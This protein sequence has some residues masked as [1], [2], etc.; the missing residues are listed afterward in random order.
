MIN[1]SYLAIAATSLSLALLLAV[2][3]LAQEEA[4]SEAAA[5]VSVE[6]V[7]DTTVTETDLDAATP[8]PF[9]FLKRAVRSVQQVVTFDP[10]KKA[11]LNLKTAHEELL[12]AQKII[13]DNPGDA[14]AATK[15][16]TALTKFQ[17]NVAK[18]KER[19]A[20]IKGADAAK[21]QIFLKK[22]ANL[23]VKQQK[24]LDNIETNLP[25]DSFSAVNDARE[26]ALE[27]GAATMTEI[28]ASPEQLGEVLDTAM[29]EQTGSDFKEFKNLEILNRLAKFVPEQAQGA[30][31][32]AQDKAQQRFE[33]RMNQIPPAERAAKFENYVGDLN[34][35]SLDQVQVLDG[36]KGQ[37]N[38]PTDFFQHVEGAKAR[39]IGKFEVKLRE[40]STPESQ[41]S[42]VGQAADGDLAGLRVLQQVKDNIPA[43][44]KQRI[45]DNQTQAINKFKEN[46][47]ANAG[48]PE[49]GQ[50]LQALTNDLRQN[51]DS[52]AFAVIQ[53]LQKTLPPAQQAFVANLRQQAAQGAVEQFQQNPQKFLQKSQSI[54]PTAVQD[55][56]GLVNQAPQLQG[57]FQQVAS[58]QTNFTKQQIENTTDP[59]RFEALQE[60]LNNNPQVSQQIQAR[61]GNF[62]QD[63]REK[64]TQIQEIKN[65][66]QGQNNVE[67]RQ[68]VE[69]Q[70]QQRQEAGERINTPAKTLP[71][72][73]QG[74]VRNNPI[75]EQK[76]QP[77]V[78]NQPV[79]KPLLENRPVTEIRENAPNS[80]K[81]DV[82]N[83]VPQQPIKTE[84]REPAAPTAG[85]TQPPLKPETQQPRIEQK[86][87]LE[88]KPIQNT[89]QPQQNF[90]VGN[91]GP[92]PSGPSGG[93]APG[94]R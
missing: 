14:E 53:D 34:G 16:K 82:Q 49:Q 39:A 43:D 80:V 51:P 37:N 33:Q 7:Q 36:M 59:A 57:I 75:Q 61:F 94:P 27:N 78:Q 85:Q 71:P 35:N 90:N 9:N 1:K 6:A 87:P 73:A 74:E 69:Q 58:Q 77:N 31:A 4:V 17:D 5:A 3:V 66:P 65:Q 93:G 11:E 67:A 60:K 50:K 68:K 19:A 29:A 28:A 41:N 64:A 79:N 76:L 54:N 8:G 86:P 23:Q 81:P 48:A 91:P 63:L 46:F 62:Q 72:A 12:R 22:I 25:A 10:V 47:T 42:L 30:I 92:G 13:K 84:V 26:S 88:V 55:I 89:P 56:Q 38:L 15:V 18:V 83:N 44:L 45:Q 70:V 40:A 20:A 24:I 32:G 52:T 2:P 21:A